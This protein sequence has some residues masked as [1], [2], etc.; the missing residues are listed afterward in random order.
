MA[1]GRIEHGCVVIQN[2]REGW[3]D[4]GKQDIDAGDQDASNGV[5]DCKSLIPAVQ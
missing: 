5:V 1:D 3:N 2:V 4:D